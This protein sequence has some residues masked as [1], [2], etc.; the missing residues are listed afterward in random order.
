MN[1]INRTS[2]NLTSACNDTKR[3][4]NAHRRIRQQLLSMGWAKH[5]CPYTA[6]KKEEEMAEYR[7]PHIYNSFFWFENCLKKINPKGEVYY[8]LEMRCLTM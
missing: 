2:K 8:A 1:N 4:T 3:I 6:N 7:S 5:K